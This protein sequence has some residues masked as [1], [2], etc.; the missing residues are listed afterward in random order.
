MNSCWMNPQA[1]ESLFD[2]ILRS[3]PRQRSGL[4]LRIGHGI[5]E[6]TYDAGFALRT[7]RNDIIPTK[8]GSQLLRHFVCGFD[9]I[10]HSAFGFMEF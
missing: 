1:Y 7:L 9:T 8:C 4:R 5:Q 3:P 10:P 6:S 2:A